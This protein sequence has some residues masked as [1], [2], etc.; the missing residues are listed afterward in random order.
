MLEDRSPRIEEKKLLWVTL[1]NITITIAQTVGGILS[2]SLALL[3]D[4]LHNLGDTFA[5]FIAYIAHRVSKRETNPQKTFGYKRVEILAALLN[6]VILIGICI[7][8]FVEAYH[9]FLDPSPVKGLL[10]LIVAII[11]LLANLYS[12]LL[13]HKDSG[14]NI[15]I[16][17]AYVHLI[18]DTLSSFV[19]IIGGVLIYFFNIYWVDPLVTVLIGIYILKEAFSILKQTV[20]ILMQFTPSGLDIQK[21]KTRLEG[22]SHIDNLH[23]IHAWNLNDQDIHFECH[24]DLTSD[25]QVSEADSIRLNMENVL[26]EEFNIKHVTIQIEYKCCDNTNMVTS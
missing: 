7:Y 26:L 9:R 3:S 10:M 15:N 5:V 17:A 14:K 22:I 12:V 8:L 4:A 23:H 16:K 21:I 1:L 20:E 24:V 13:L 2:N 19:V 11:G 25:L 6:A 18:G